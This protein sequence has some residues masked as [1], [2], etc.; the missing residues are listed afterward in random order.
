MITASRESI[1]QLLLDL[2]KVPGVTR[3]PEE[4]ETGRFIRRKLETIPWVKAHPESII[5]VPLGDPLGRSIVGC[6]LK[7]GPQKAD[8]VILTG[9]YDVVGV[10]DF[11]PLRHLA[12]SPLEYTRALADAPLEG[13]VQKDL[14]SGEYLFGRGIMDMKAGLAVEMALLAEASKNPESLGV[15]L[16]F[17]AVPDE[18]DSSLGMRGAVSLLSELREKEG[19]TYKGAIL[20]EPSSAGAPEEAGET[21]FTGTVGKLMP[22][23]Y[24]LGAGSHVGQYFRGLNA[25]LL[26][27]CCN[28]LMEAN[29]DFAESVGGETTPPPACLYLRDIRKGYSVTLPDR[30]VAF[31]NLMTLRRSPAEIL[32][33]LKLLA[34]KAFSM[35]VDHLEGSAQALKAGEFRRFFPKVMT[36]EEFLAEAGRRVPDVKEFIREKVAALDK[37]LDDREKALALLGELC[38]LWNTREPAIIVGFLPPWYPHRENAEDR[39]S[40]RLAMQVAQEVAAEAKEQYGIDM[41][42]RAFFG[43]ICDLSYLGYHGSAFDPFCV[44]A[45]MPGWGSVYRLPVKELTA[46]DVPVLN[47]GVS[48][49]DPHKPTER[50][51]LPF[52]LDVLPELLRRAIDC[53]ARG[54][55]F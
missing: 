10:E 29:P 3:T 38:D 54:V 20:T 11:G 34:E 25:T 28:S 23:F 1:L 53:F 9:H 44:A 45:N 50:L 2:V 30:A 6:L 41:G 37:G 14:A 46:L 51:H 42:I 48:G 15:N 24:C 8:T 35:A 12:F 13:E 39:P 33:D 27:S 55:T 47:I 40:D 16:L 26:V 5:D 52:T 4:A 7:A 17:L 49:K 19:L 18:E 36:F 22:F 43:G 31:Y 32:K 21:I